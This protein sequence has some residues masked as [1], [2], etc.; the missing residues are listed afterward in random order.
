MNLSDNYSIHELKKKVRIF[1]NGLK[2]VIETHHAYKDAREVVTQ[3]DC[4]YP[5]QLKGDIW[6]GHCGA[7]TVYFWGLEKFKEDWFLDFLERM[8]DKGYVMVGAASQVTSETSY[9]KEYKLEKKGKGVVKVLVDLSSTAE[10]CTL[11]KV[12]ETI[13][14]KY[15]VR[16]N[17]D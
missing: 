3:I 13:V 11:V 7:V 14:P 8:D 6:R 2:Q 4:D 1:K 15:E 12:G 16:C 17:N 9:G 10:G 5:K